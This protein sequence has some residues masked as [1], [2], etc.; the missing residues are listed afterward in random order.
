MK[1]NAV[2]HVPRVARDMQVWPEQNRSP[3]KE[4]YADLLEDL[5]ETVTSKSQLKKLLIKHRA[6]ALEEDKKRAAE[7]L[8][9]DENS[10]GPAM[11]RA[12]LGCFF[13]HVGL[14]RV[15]LEREF[16]EGF[17]QTPEEKE[18]RKN[19]RLRRRGKARH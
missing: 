5:K 18:E 11:E 17:W 15:A 3:K 1:F 10:S 16:G 8:K 7:I 6:A 4:D 9:G 13:V 14:T 2:L 12:K 19:R